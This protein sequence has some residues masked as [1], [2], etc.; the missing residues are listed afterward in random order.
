MMYLIED[1]RPRHPRKRRVLKKVRFVDI[2]PPNSSSYPIDELPGGVPGHQDLGSLLSN[3]LSHCEALHR[4]PL[5]A[6]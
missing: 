3:N 1:L 5:S 2:M 6:R 4:E